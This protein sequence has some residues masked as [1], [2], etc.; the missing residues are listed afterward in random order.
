MPKTLELV[1][2]T[3]QNVFTRHATQFGM[4]KK[5]PKFGVFSD[6]LQPPEIHRGYP[7]HTENWDEPPKFL[8]VNS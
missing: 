5:P 8:R 3:S 1:G 2:V 4:A 7:V 6:N